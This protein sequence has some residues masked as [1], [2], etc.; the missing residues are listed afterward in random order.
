MNRKKALFLLMVFGLVI[1]CTRAEEDFG[2]VARVNGQAISL[3]ELEARYDLA[4]L[5]GMDEL[6]PSV[7][8][9]REDYG[10]LLGNLIIQELIHQELKKKGLSI[11]DDELE[12]AEKEIR[13]DYPDDVFEQVLIE[14]CIDIDFWR[15]QLRNRMAT[16]RFFNDVLRPRITIQFSEAKQYFNTHIEDFYL[17][18]RVEFMVFHGSERDSLEKKVKKYM[19][20]PESI[21][22]PQE[23]GKIQVHQLK[24][25]EDRLPPSWHM[26][27]KNLDPG[28][29]GM[30]LADS[31]GFQTFFVLDK[32][33]GKFLDPSAAY[34][35]V[36]RIL[37]EQ[38]LNSLFDEWLTS[39]LEQA[40][41]QVSVHLLDQ[42]RNRAAQESR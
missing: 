2:V 21:Q 40:D 9:L 25:R 17:P 18:A 16:E 15:S 31:S 4:Q 39:A 36:E 26:A 5:D 37:V 13:E 22:T 7:S 30:V 35:L 20:N 6:P 28:Q 3:S 41:I 34:P 33:P 1:G 11:S 14:E 8:K 24:M 38:K 10:Q 12:N 32:Y 27:L 23:T 29:K 42:F 19:K